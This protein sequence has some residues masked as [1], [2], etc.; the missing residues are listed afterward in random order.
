MTPCRIN[1]LFDFCAMVLF[2]KLNIWILIE[3]FDLYFSM[4]APWCYLNSKI[5]LF[6]QLYSANSSYRFFR[7]GVIIDFLFIIEINS[8]ALGYLNF[9]SL[10]LIN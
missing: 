3:P 4:T 8:I 10:K 1:R 2:K 5:Q 7:H 6:K 9:Y